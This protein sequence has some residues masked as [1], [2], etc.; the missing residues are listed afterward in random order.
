VRVVQGDAPDPEACITLDAF[1]I[2]GLP[3][4]RPA[5][6]LVK[7][8][9]SYDTKGRVHVTAED[10]SAAKTMTVEINRTKGMD[11]S[12]ITAEMTRL[13]LKSVE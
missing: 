10:V 11:P 12:R 7:V 3:E 4:G 1:S 5:G 2:T 9:F 8:T 13:S 6:A